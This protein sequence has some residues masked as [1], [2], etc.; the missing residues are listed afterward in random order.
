VSLFI[1]AHHALLVLDGLGA[2]W[3]IVEDDLGRLVAIGAGIVPA[4]HRSLHELR[5]GLDEGRIL[6]LVFQHIEAVLQRGHTHVLILEGDELVGGMP[7][8]ITCQYSL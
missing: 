6:Q 2:R 5:H 8:S 4:L 3:R 1:S 7:A